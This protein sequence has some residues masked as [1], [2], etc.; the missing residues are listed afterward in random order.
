[1]FVGTG[2][3]G[4]TILMSVF[5]GLVHQSNPSAN[6]LSTLNTMLAGAWL[7]IAYLKTKTLYFSFGMHF[8]WNLVQSFF[9]S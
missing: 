7:S 5:F 2:A 3:I 9:F 8:S 6:L 4:A 1:M